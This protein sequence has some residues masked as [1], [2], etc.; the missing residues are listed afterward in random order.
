VAAAGATGR[1]ATAAG[2]C[3]GGSG[4]SLT[5]AAFRDKPAGGH[6]FR[7]FFAFTGRAVRLLASENQVFK[8][9]IAVFTEIFV[10]RHKILQVPIEK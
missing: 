6:Q 9:L 5:A 3:A 7:Y 4:Y 10:D 8:F 2:G 1:C